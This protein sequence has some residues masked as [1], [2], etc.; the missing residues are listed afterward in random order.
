VKTVEI[1]TETRPLAEWLPKED[2]DEV[3]YLTREGRARFVVVPLDEG[4]AEVLAVRNNA[5]LMAHI[6]A[7]MERARSG[8]TRTLAEIK[9][10]L[11]L[12]NGNGDSSPSSGADASK[13]AGT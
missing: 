5:R 10:E 8:P 12:G 6:A 1:D 9:A 3:V 2:S 4:D 13:T 7:C 11:G